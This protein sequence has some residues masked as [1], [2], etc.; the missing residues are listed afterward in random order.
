[1]PRAD[2]A[3][4]TIPIAS[5]SVSGWGGGPAATVRIA[6]P[7]SLEEA[8][9]AIGHA[10][11]GAIA[12]GM[13]RSYGDAAQL[14]RGLVIDTTRLKRFELDAER[15]AVTA[16]AGVT[17]AELLAALVPAGWMVPVV[18]GTQHVTVGGAIASDIHGK[19]HGAAGTFGTYVEALGLL[20]SDGEVR[21]LSANDHDPAF[22]ATIGG[23]GL[24]GVIL[25]AR[26]RL[27]AVSSAL[28]SVDSDR[29]ETLDD[30]LAALSAAGGSYRVAWLDLLSGS[31]VRGI[32]TRAEHL[33]AADVPRDA[34]GHATVRAKATVP[35]RWPHSLLH[36]A[37]V[38]AFNELRFRS[39]PRAQ[40]EAV[41]SIGNHMFPLDALDAWPRLYGR[42]GF[43]QYQ[44]VVPYGAE[45]ALAG[46][47]EHL[48]RASVSCYLAVLKDFGPANGFPLSFPIE[49]WTLALDLPRATPGLEPALDRLDELVA[50][51]GGRIYLTKDTRVRA[52]TLAA[53]YPRLE[54]WRQARELV[55]PERLWRS[56]L[57]ERTGLVSPRTGPMN[58]P[59]AERTNAPSAEP[60]NVARSEP[61]NVAR[62]DLPT[63][64]LLVGGTSEIGLAIVRRL[65]NRGAVSPYLV[66]RDR[67]RL[68]GALA[69]LEPQGFAGGEVDVLD[70]DD[71]DSHPAVIARAF[72]RSGGF[73]IVVLAVGVLGA[74]AG[75]DATRDQVLEVMRTNFV[76]TGSVLLECL[77]RL[78]EQ[79]SGT[80]I[81]LSSVAAERP[82]ANNAIY[83]AAKAGLDSLSQGLADATGGSGVRVL[84]V[85]PGF[86]TTKMT[87][88]LRPAPMATTAD[89]VAEAT[90]RALDG[91][92][93][94]IWVPGRLRLVFSVLRH[95]PRPVFR[96]LPR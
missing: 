58:A 21:E 25:W 28:L 85:R 56:D 73:D 92:A 81:V 65:G 43:V 20:T 52:E 64:V 90:V 80:L 83:G 69:A 1:M 19:N 79:G 33:S 84:V 72:G 78:R 63:R 26:I 15:G 17:L 42:D 29:V 38:R 13:G 59:S 44:L 36:P 66:G 12:R 14:A 9:E 16:E 34:D 50:G 11:C 89:A 53:M 4:G 96:R 8:R 2:A 7:R 93:H 41:E 87:A 67:Q 45:A 32:V 61:T 18:P 76:G 82:R 37:T 5:G 94:T 6:R 24:T 74:Q 95:L 40:R 55:D 57:A 27:R 3:V 68:A 31:R 10:E 70:A 39:A 91:Q 51:A 22:A 71:L 77:T 30:A 46:A 49:G 54:E 47:I 88:G 62:S 23:M 86:V 60:T 48:R 75:L 35:A